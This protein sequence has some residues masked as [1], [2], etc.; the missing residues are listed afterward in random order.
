VRQAAWLEASALFCS[1]AGQRLAVLLSRKNHRQAA[2]NSGTTRQIKTQAPPGS[3]RLRHRQA[4]EKSL[5]GSSN[6][7][8]E[9][10]AER[11]GVCL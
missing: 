10:A 5:P 1:S 11:W 4:A 8:P 6:V 2:Q 9:I 3:S 7:G